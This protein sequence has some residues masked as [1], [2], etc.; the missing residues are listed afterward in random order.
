M[1]RVAFSIAAALVLTLIPPGSPAVAAQGL[2]VHF[3]GS[4]WGHGVGM[5]Q[6]GANA[7]ATAGMTAEQILTYYYSGA[8]VKPL[9]Q[10]LGAEG[11][12][13]TDPDPLWIGLAQ[14]QTSLRFQVQNGQA[15]LCKSGDGE[16]ECAPPLNGTQYAGAGENWEFRTLGNG[17][18]RF[19]KEGVAV[20]NPGTCRASITWLDQPNTRVF[21]PDTGRTYARG[22]LRMR[23]NG[24][25]AFHVMLEM[26]LED[27]VYGIGEVP[28]S[29]PV[30]A[31][32]AQA[33]AAR[34]YGVR[35]A[36]RWGP[37]AGLAAGRQAQ[38]WCQLFST[39]VDQNYVGWSKESGLDGNRWVQAV[40]STAGLVVTHPAAPE[41]T[42]ITAY[43][44]S[45][46]GG[47]TE[48]NVSGLGHTS[49]IPYLVS[50]PDPWSQD[51][52]NP[53]A[54][55][56]KDLTGVDVAAAYGL[57]SLSSI[58]VTARNES[59]SAAEVVIQ[60]LL[61]G[62]QVT[63]TRTGRSV[64]STLG[65]RSSYFDVSVEVSFLPPFKD[66]EGSIYEQDIVTIYQAGITKGCEV[67]LYCPSAAVPRWQM[68]LYL[69]RLHSASGYELPTGAPQ[70]FNDLRGV[71]A[72]AGLAINQ[73]RQ[74]GI[75]KGTST[76]TY[77]PGA[78][79]PRWQMALFITRMLAADGVP[80]P[81]GSNQGFTDIGHLSAEAQ[82][83]INQLRQ[84]GVTTLSGQYS[85]DL[86][87]ARDLMASFM[88]EALD[89]V[90]TV[91]GF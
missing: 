10:A 82:K 70:G 19:F 38:C 55:W 17:A 57:S 6:Y 45:S 33:I 46:S 53:Y 73:L 71:S 43:Y 67:D 40:A 48:S 44:S 14:D 63:L 11:F 80:L 75:T 62:S 32:E 66:D 49:L 5:S 42:I 91:V 89:L 28:S 34:T 1:R 27:Y 12:M 20:G 81:D 51:P 77:T 16:G 74:L 86:P 64:K 54:A 52:F 68:A 85:P 60:G 2:L 90:R 87:M 21:F 31:L 36:L 15:G 29:W 50:V 58:T 69:T 72:E 35:Q 30:E 25:A 39:V 24:P 59:G 65:L 7:M 3:E 22:T 78:E 41:Q 76:T 56:T 4:G 83:A 9:A 18:C 88:A 23:P 26:G 8:T 13:Q 37:E 84:L 61:N 79:V 47:K